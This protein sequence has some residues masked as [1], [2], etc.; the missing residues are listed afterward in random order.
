MRI[1]KVPDQT[2]ETETKE[3]RGKGGNHLHFTKE[4]DRKRIVGVKSNISFFE[5]LQQFARP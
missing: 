3:Y 1:E 2:R 4:I 5:W